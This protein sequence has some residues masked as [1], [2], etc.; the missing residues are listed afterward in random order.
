MGDPDDGTFTVNV[1]FAAVMILCVAGVAFVAAKM[2]P[3]RKKTGKRRAKFLRTKF[4]AVSNGHKN[5]DYRQLPVNGVEGDCVLLETE[6]EEDNDS[7]EN[8]E[9]KR[10]I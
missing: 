10:L 6:S 4:K 1:L 5:G 9:V 7:I 8:I 3:C 2:R